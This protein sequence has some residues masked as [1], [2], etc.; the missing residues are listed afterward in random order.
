[1]TKYDDTRNPKELYSTTVSE[2]AP[3]KEQGFHL[4]STEGRIVF[5]E[6]DETYVY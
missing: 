2:L 6:T 3:L 5:K 1:M 4:A